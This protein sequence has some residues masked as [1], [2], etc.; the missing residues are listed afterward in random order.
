MR[1]SLS[2]RVLDSVIVPRKSRSCRVT[3]LEVSS[4]WPLTTPS[5]L[6]SF[7]SGRRHAIATSW[8][9]ATAPSRGRSERGRGGWVRLFM[10]LCVVTHREKV[11]MSSV[12]TR[13]QEE[14]LATL[15]QKYQDEEGGAKLILGT[16]SS[17]KSLYRAY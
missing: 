4:A 17:L 6:L 11:K 14:E 3:W 10:C 1:L 7:S 15:Y 9:W 8:R 13:E 2:Q 16:K 12:W 5:C